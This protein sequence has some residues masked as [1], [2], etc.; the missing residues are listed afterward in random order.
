MKFAKL[1]IIL[2]VFVLII[3]SLY[4]TADALS[5]YGSNGEEVRQIQKKLKNWGYYKGNVFSCKKYFWLLW[6]WWSFRY[7]ARIPSVYRWVQVH[8]MLS[9]K[10]AGLRNSCRCQGKG[11]P[12]LPSSKLRCS[13]WCA[14][15]KKQIL[16]WGR[17]FVKKL[18]DNDTAEASII[19]ESIK[20][21]KDSENQINLCKIAINENIY[22]EAQNFIERQ[23]YAAAI[24]KL[25]T[26][27]WFINVYFKI[28]W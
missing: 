22:N 13:V 1:L 17:V 11:H 12:P 26:R 3:V 20:E 19:F 6:A 18:L 28:Q 5:R 7:Y 24:S 8:E 21:F 23:Y 2:A 15:E 10:G 27:S 9:H 16:S 4:S 25:E 14:Q